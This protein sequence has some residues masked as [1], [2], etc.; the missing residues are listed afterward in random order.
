MRP[1]FTLIFVFSITLLRCT[2][3]DNQTANRSTWEPPTRAP[4]EALDSLATNDWWN[5]KPNDIVQLDVP[6]DQVVA[7]GMYTVANNTLKLSAQLFPLYPDETRTVRLE[8]KEE[9]DWKEIQQQEVNDLGWSALFR[10]ENWE[11][12][13]DIPYRLRHGEQAMFEGLIRK[14]PSG[15]NE[16]V[17]AALS[18]NSNQDRGMRENYVRNINHQ[19]PDLVF[20]AGDQ[21]YD[22]KQHT[23]AWLKFGLQFR[24]V[25]RN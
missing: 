5:R 11:A 13:Q 9:D 3:V 8:V 18:C 25:F 21:S 4:F 16:I 19:N 14:D 24:E 6:R 1:S 17:L 12:S 10:V 23:A 22:H 7:F 2:S 20:F 15:K